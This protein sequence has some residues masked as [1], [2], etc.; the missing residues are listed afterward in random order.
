MMRTQWTVVL[1]LAGLLCGWRAEAQTWTFKGVVA[2]GKQCDAV[3]GADNRIHLVTSR[4]Y[5]FDANGRKVLDQ[6]YPAPDTAQGVMD[7]NPGIARDSGGNVHII[8]R[9][10]GNW[11][12]GYE[13]W[14][15]KRTAAG[16]WSSYKAANPMVRNY[17]VGIAAADNGMVYFTHG[18]APGG[19]VWGP[20]KF[21]RENG[22]AMK[23]L[24]DINDVWRTDCDQVIRA[25]GNELFFGSGKC[26]PGGASYFSRT[27]AVSSPV[28]GLNANLKTH[29]S[30]SDRRGYPAMAID[31]TGQFHVAYGA[32][33]TVFY[34]K[35]NGLNAK[36][37][38]SDKLIF[39]GLGS[40]HNNSGL[41]SVAVSDDGRRVV[42]VA[43][44]PD[45]KSSN[46][47]NCDLLYSYS[48]D[49]G[50]SWSKA[51]RIGRYTDAG[52]G[53][54]RPALVW[55][56]D[57]IFMFYVDK[58]G[59]TGTSL[60]I[61][62]AKRQT[63]RKAP[64]AES[65]YGVWAVARIADAAARDPGADPDGDGVDNFGEFVADTD[66]GD[67]DSHLTLQSV[68]SGDDVILTFP[69][70]MSR[71]YRVQYSE[72]VAQDDWRDL[73]EQEI[74]QEADGVRMVRDAAAGATRAY[75]LRV[76]MP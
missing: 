71:R 27:A 3:R 55:V 33:G 36:V 44:N 54:C 10:N 41:C 47:S 45:G 42:I 2:E 4:Y 38:A 17:Q 53:R 69:V 59:S 9:R 31:L 26:D 61:L 66:P 75:R 76:M 64:A 58:A 62:E 46:A 70:S 57:K 19:N 39:S 65:N 24:G 68:V 18:A 67:G 8:A 43:L 49:G 35:Y 23:L 34:N 13:L 48:L 22:G 7:Y 28:A 12:S 5:Q 21:Y 25:R 6:A 32:S 29:T 63:T 74:L 16:A 15:S 56:A 30:G 60:A 37:F 1:V 14:Y 40:W 20:V 51:V 50:T 72:D 73:P 11:T 52:E